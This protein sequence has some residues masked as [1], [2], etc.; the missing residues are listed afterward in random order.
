MILSHRALTSL[1]MSSYRAI[2]TRFGPNFMFFE[3]KISEPGPKILILVPRNIR[4]WSQNPDPGPNKYHILDP[5]NCFCLGATA[6]QTP[7]CSWGASSP[8]DPLA[9][10]LQPPAHP[11]SIFERLRL[12]DSPFIFLVPRSWYQ[13]LWGNRSLG[14]RGTALSTNPN[15]Y[16]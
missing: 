1:N 13:D 2:W 14:D 6:P 7:C 11:R 12:L 15:R 16:P 5:S 9:G 8:P 4:S 3:P 10:G